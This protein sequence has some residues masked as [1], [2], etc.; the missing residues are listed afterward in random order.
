MRRERFFNLLRREP[1]YWL[2]MGVL[3]ITLIGLLVL[4]L[5]PSTF[6]AADPERILEAPSL[7]HWFGTDDLGRDVLLQTFMVAGRSVLIAFG[8]T[9]LASFLAFIIGLLSGYF[10]GWLEW[11]FSAL[12]EVFLAI[13][14]FV[15]TT[16]LVVYFRPDTWWMMVIL[17]CSS[18]MPLARLIREE[19]L[20]MK[21]HVYVV[22]AHFI[23]EDPFK[24]LLRHILPGVLPAVLAG[25]PL[26]VARVLMIEA[27]LSYLG[28]GIQGHLTTWGSYMSTNQQY[29]VTHPYMIV[30]PAILFILTIYAFN[31]L[32]RLLQLI[33]DMEGRY[34]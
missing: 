25:M 14:T 24:I 12:V 13:P 9:L 8:A 20:R 34:A 21:E 32:G 16:L 29:L 17:G 4:P 3:L 5:V 28:V 11:L 6:M 31:Q 2:M 33:F 18:W 10:R 26:S 27:T 7:S 23:G 19:T 1:S 15:L 30:L 22:Y